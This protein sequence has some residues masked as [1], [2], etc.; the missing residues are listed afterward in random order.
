[1]AYSK[2]AL[3]L[4]FNVIFFTLVSSTS[5]PCPPPPPKSHHKKPATPSP[6][7]TCKDA[8]KLKVCANVL[9][10]VKVS[11]PPTSN[12]CALIKGLVDLEAAVCLC[13]ALKANVLGINLNVPISL[14][15][16]LNHCG[17]KVP[18]GFK[19]A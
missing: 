2:I 7:P 3:L 9:D 5:V 17:K 16:V 6:K 4:I 1:M 15:V 8:L 19:C 12:C 11:L 14:N 10:L 13:T 18:S